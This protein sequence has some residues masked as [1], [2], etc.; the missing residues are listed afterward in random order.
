MDC[1][2]VSEPSCG[3]ELMLCRTLSSADSSSSSLDT[4]FLDEVS[5]IYERVH[6]YT[7]REHTSQLSF[8]HTL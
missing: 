3:S 5:K 1:C 4:E 2:R 6:E 7:N 8:E